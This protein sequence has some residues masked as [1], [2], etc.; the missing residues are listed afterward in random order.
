MYTAKRRELLEICRLVY[1]RHLTNAAGSNFS[2][3]AS[4]TTLYVSIN[5]NA[6]RNRLRMTA[7][8][9]LLATFDS[10]VLEGEGK[11]SQSWRTHLKMYQEFDFVG[12]AIHAHPR[13]ATAF[14]CRDRAMPP[15]LDAMKKYGEIPV[16]PR[17]IKVDSPEFADAI[18]EIFRQK[19][20]SFRK[21]GHAVLYPFHG[22]FVVAPTLDDAYDLL[23]R[24]EYN[25]TA[26]LSSVL[27]DLG[28]FGKV[29]EE[30]KVGG[31]MPALSPSE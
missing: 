25:A 9:L 18:A 5:G 7:D 3:R 23:E 29:I 21:Y 19:G 27:L 26:I 30:E 22:V 10:Q 11:F 24:I 16:V 31:G 13:Y 15:F 14:A 2:A 17:N 12:A 6:K 20:E 28:H 1:D 8:D 4:E